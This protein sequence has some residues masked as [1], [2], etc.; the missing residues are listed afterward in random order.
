[1]SFRLAFILLVIV[2]VAGVASAG[3]SDSRV[4]PGPGYRYRTYAPGAVKPT[5]FLNEFAKPS[6]A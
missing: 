2:G 5:G 1:M 6:P 3:T 4:A